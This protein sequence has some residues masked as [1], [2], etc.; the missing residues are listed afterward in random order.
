MTDTQ[1]L[2]DALAANFMLVDLDIRSWSGNKTDREVS[3]EIIA[4]RGASRDSGKFVKYLFATADTEL[5]TV[6]R[7]G[8]A[9]REYVRQ[10]SAPWQG[11]YRLLPATR[12]I[13]F[14]T[15]LNGLKQ[16]YDNAV[17]ALA[18][19]WDQRVAQAIQS[20]NGLANAADY[21]SSSEVPK[22][23]TMSIDL[24]PVPSEKDFSRINLPSEVIAA[25]GQRHATMLETQMAG[26]HADLKKGLLTTVER[27][28]AQLGKAGAGEKTRLCDS[29]VSNLQKQVD[30]LRSMNAAG[31]PE[32]DALASK[33]EAQ[34]LA[35]PVDT[36]RNSRS[37]AAEVAEAAKA[38]A[39]EAA[40]EDVWK[41]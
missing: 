25:L 22:L 37:K 34:L 39:V 23:F 31:K 28:A 20:L 4:A 8:R 12:A 32:L 9:I 17:S 19:V 29:L 15:A 24:R 36:Y 41:I 5:Q 40:M 13:E 6:Q 18:A 16:D 33:I 2:N 10:N 1:Q 21:P 3:S 26:V 14:L 27:M 7:C 30:L 35:A 38:L 11:E